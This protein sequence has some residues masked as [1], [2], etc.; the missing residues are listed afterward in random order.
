[1]NSLLLLLAAAPFLTPDGY[2]PARIGMTQKQVSTALGVRL[3]GEP[4][5]EESTCVEKVAVGPRYP[6]VV[7]MFLDGRLSR[8]SIG[9]PSKART[10]RGIG[11]G[12]GAD[13]V[14]RAYGAKLQA[15]E[16]HYVGKPAEYLTYWT[17]PRQRGVRFE[18]DTKRKVET[19]HA[20]NDSIQY[21]EGCA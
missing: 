14:R 1:V 6:G 20:G 8:V 10:P 5:D 21:I 4:I 16:H 13:A 12:A 15:E 19:I 3:K 9:E 18:T 11:I 17:R 7:F 2:G